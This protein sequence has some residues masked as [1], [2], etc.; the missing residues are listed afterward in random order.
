[1][2]P[3][4]ENLACTQLLDL[5]QESYLH[6]KGQTFHALQAKENKKDQLASLLQILEQRETRK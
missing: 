5:L 6:P 4:R 1:M 2:D 3:R